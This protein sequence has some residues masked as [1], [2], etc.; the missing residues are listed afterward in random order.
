MRAP[1]KNDAIRL[2]T[3]ALAYGAATVRIYEDYISN[4]RT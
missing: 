3:A 4:Y 1:K 2:A